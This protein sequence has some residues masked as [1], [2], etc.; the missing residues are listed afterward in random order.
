M[1]H[2]VIETISLKNRGWA[3]GAVGAAVAERAFGAGTWWVSLGRAAHLG[4][5]Q[6]RLLLFR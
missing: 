2:I 6:G 4:V 1:S 3:L 5:C